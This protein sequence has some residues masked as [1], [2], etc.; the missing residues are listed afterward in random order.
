MILRAF[1]FSMAL[2]GAL[3][4]TATAA[5]L[6]VGMIGL[7]TSH[8][9]EFTRRFNDPTDK[10]FVPGARVVVDIPEGNKEMLAHSVKIG[11]SAKTVDT[12]T[13]DSH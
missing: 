1:S 7:D 10:E 4:L 8:V 5:D 2:C 6:R 11:T 13:H 12:H 3:S 9:V